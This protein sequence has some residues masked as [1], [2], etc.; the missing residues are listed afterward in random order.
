[1]LA[2]VFDLSAILSDLTG[3]KYSRTPVFVLKLYRAGY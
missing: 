2:D 1:M 3:S